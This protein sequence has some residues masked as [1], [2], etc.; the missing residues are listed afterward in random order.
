MVAGTLLAHG[1]MV[2]DGCRKDG[3]KAKGKEYRNA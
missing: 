3:E 1:M 2:R